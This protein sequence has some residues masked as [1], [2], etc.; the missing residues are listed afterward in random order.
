M[1]TS[2]QTTEQLKAEILR[3]REMEEQ[4]KTEII[5]RI[6]TP[7]ALFHTILSVYSNS[8]GR[9]NDSKGSIFNQDMFGILSRILLPLT[10]NKTIF[11][12]SNFVVKT[13]VGFLSQKA[14]HFISEDSLAGLIN[15]VRSIFDRKN[16]N[17]DYGIPPDSEAS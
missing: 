12:N 14:S 7:S 5:K 15:K 16:K 8:P 4:Q 10:L 2:I 11:R 3:L 6:N 9:D 17:S 1:D 13:L